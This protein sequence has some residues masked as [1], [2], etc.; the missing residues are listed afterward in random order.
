[1]KLNCAAEAAVRARER[2]AFCAAVEKLTN[3]AN[4]QPLHQSETQNRLHT[5]SAAV[6]P[7]RGCMDSQNGPF[8]EQSIPAPRIRLALCQTPP[9]KHHVFA[10]EMNSAL[11]GFLCPCTQSAACHAPPIIDCSAR[12]TA[13]ARIP[14]CHSSTLLPMFTALCRF[15]RHLSSAVR[16]SSLQRSLAMHALRMPALGAG[17]THTGGARGGGRAPTLSV[18]LPLRDAQRR[19]TAPCS[20]RVWGQQRCRVVEQGPKAV[21]TAQ[22]APE[23]PRVLPSRTS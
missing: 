17:S 23:P 18:P 16:P 9:A 10:H 14:G 13:P 6:F 4:T 20:T 11:Q 21:A 12:L 8:T 7:R 1:M 5:L 2:L 19:W 3:K 15:D 22:G